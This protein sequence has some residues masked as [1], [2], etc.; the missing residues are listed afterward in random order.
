MQADRKRRVR[1]A[2][3]LYQRP[4]DGKF[5]IGFSDS[6]GRW[7]IKTLRRQN[8]RR[9]QRPSATSSCP[10][11]VLDRSPLQS[12][13]TFAEVAAEYVAGLEAIRRRRRQG[14]KDTRALQRQHLDGHILPDLGHIQVQK[15]T[16]D[17]LA[18]FLRDRQATGLSSWTRKGMLTPLS[19]VLSLGRASRV[20]VRESSPAASSLKSCRRARRRTSLAFSI[21]TRS[22]ACSPHATVPV[23]SPRSATDGLR[24]AASDGTPR[25]A[26]VVRRLRARASSQFATSSRAA[27]RRARR[28]SSN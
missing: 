9:R 16:A 2:P 3:N 23:Q 28:G 19:R 1:I 15:L 26:L 7:R 6:G 13:I 5:E 14:V 10:S 20:P 11:F 4:S 27:R 21:A 8:V 17:A 22:A 24:R 25:A 12:K 18:A